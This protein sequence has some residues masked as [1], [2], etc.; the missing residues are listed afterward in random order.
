MMSLFF[1]APGIG[2]QA[3][4]GENNFPENRQTVLE[5]NKQ[6]SST[7]LLGARYSLR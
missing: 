5:G 2:E 4:T 1:L 7:H 3:G 6:V